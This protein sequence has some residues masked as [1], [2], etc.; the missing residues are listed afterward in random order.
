VRPAFDEIDDDA[1]HAGRAG[2]AL[3]AGVGEVPQQ[4]HAIE[5]AQRQGDAPWRVAGP[6]PRGA[7]RRQG[8]RVNSPPP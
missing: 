2:A 4:D 3:E 7:K 8:S 1:G 6:E 5:L